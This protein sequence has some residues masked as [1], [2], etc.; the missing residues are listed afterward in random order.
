MP[1]AD[2][3]EADANAVVA[4]PC[5]IGQ[6]ARGLSAKADGCRTGRVDD[7]KSGLS[8]SPISPLTI[9]AWMRVAG[10]SFD[11]GPTTRSRRN[12]RTPLSD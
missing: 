4:S 1:Q 7:P 10:H 3:R 8:G 5:A 9:A 2:R 11:S 6:A 12:G